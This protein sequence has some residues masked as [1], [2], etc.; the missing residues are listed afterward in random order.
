[1]NVLFWNIRRLGNDPAKGMLVDLRRAHKPD[2]VAIAEP[3]IRR[4][5]L[6]PRFWKGLRLTF[7]DENFRGGGL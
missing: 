4:T 5:D 7:L 6:S 3:K 1:M 2:I